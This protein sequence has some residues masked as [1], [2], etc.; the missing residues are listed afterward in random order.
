M[1]GTVFHHLD[2]NLH[3]PTY[4]DELGKRFEQAC[5]TV[6]S[7]K[8]FEVFPDRLNLPFQYIPANASP[9]VGQRIKTSTD[10]DVIARKG[11]FLFVIE[12]KE[13]TRPKRGTSRLQN[14]LTRVS[15]DLQYKT[16]WIRAN[17]QEVSKLLGSEWSKLLASESSIWYVPL[18]VS[19]FP[20]DLPS[21]MR[22]AVLSLSELERLAEAIEISRVAKSGIDYFLS[23]KDIVRSSS[24][25]TRIFSRQS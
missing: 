7:S 23:V 11:D 18:L 17:T 25:D 14:L 3:S 24:S 8:G 22:S 13:R 19:N 5:R 10:I 12:C 6:L 9:L 1:M 15:I 2:Y 21:D 16:L 4:S 20:I